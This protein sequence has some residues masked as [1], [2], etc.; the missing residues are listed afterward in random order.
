MNQPSPGAFLG[1]VAAFLALAAFVWSWL[2]VP[3][4]EEKIYFEVLFWGGGHT[5]QFQHA[6]LMVVAWLWI[7]AHLGQPGLVDEVG[8]GQGDQAELD[9]EEPENV[10]VLAGLDGD[11]LVGGH[12]Q[13]GGV[14]VA[15]PGGHGLDELLMARDVDKDDLLR[16]GEI[17]E[18]DEAEFD[19][20]APGL[21]FGQGVGV[22]PG[23]G[24]DQ[25]A[26]AVVD[27]A[28]RADDDV[29]EVGHGQTERAMRAGP[30]RTTRPMTA[31]AET[32]LA[33]RAATRAAA[34]D[35]RTAISRPPEVWGS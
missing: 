13:E 11:A 23:Q 33:R 28:G 9:V 17:V 12:D 26:L 7:A 20:H 22:G 2:V 5:L 24:L 25:G 21:L 1:A 35:L 31:A 14:D 30:L 16:V 34:R 8:L 10:E 4:I 6:L 32:P 27:V 29:V 15:G 3:R 19:G 18:E